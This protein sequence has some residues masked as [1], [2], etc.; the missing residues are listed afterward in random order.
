MSGRHHAIT[1]A[2]L[3]LAV[4]SFASLQA[5]ATPGTQKSTSST[6]AAS[7]DSIRRDSKFIHEAA[8][9]NLLEV[10]LGEAAQ[11]KAGNPAVKQF[12]QQMVADHQ[13]LQD[14]WTVMASKHGVSFTPGLGPLHQRK[15]DR[16]QQADPKTFDREYVAT[17][18]RNHMDAVSYLKNEGESARSAPVRKLVA[19][20]LPMLQDHL[21]SAWRL[22]KDVGVDSTVVARARVT[23]RS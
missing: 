7:T 2:G 4:A 20:E 12:A 16:L 9:D 6:A 5:Q 15:L 21:K 11:R 14:Q 23:A 8:A 3:L 10:R 17:V 19:Y 18:I 1:A 22:G 13:K